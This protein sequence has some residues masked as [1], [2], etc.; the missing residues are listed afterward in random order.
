MNGN[1]HPHCTVNTMV[2]CLV[3]YQK[4][5]RDISHLNYMLHPARANKKHIKPLHRTL[6]PANYSRLILRLHLFL[7]VCTAQPF[8]YNGPLSN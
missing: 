4:G 1:A 3:C 2:F 6:F 7:P 5:K 8:H